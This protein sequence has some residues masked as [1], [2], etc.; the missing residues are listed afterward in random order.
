MHHYLHAYCIIHHS[1]SNCCD[2][3]ALLYLKINHSRIIYSVHSVSENA[4]I[5]TNA[6]VCISFKQVSIHGLY[7][8]FV[9][10]LSITLHHNEQIATIINGT[11]YTRHIEFGRPPLQHLLPG[12]YTSKVS[13]IGN[14]KQLMCEHV[15]NTYFYYDIDDLVHVYNVVTQHCIL[16]TAAMTA[17]C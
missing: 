9:S 4:S 10:D 3:V 16:N 7:H 13:A 1:A 17:V 11:G 2:Y 6:M 8:E 12:S 15:I 5:I 14:E